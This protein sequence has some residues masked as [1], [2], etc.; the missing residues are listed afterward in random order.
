MFYIGINII[1]STNICLQIKIIV[2]VKN[3][4]NRTLIKFFK[5][6]LIKFLS[7]FSIIY[8]SVTSMYLKYQYFRKENN[9]P[10][11]LS[12][13]GNIFEIFKQKQQG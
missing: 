11:G 13:F 5:R 7:H 9:F 8:N 6:I 10:S 1:C 2:P 3:F 4:F 12:I